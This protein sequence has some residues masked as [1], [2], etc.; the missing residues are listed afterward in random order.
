MQIACRDPDR[1]S[2]G[3][4]SRAR[5]FLLSSFVLNDSGSSST[6]PSRL[7]RMFVEYQPVDAEQPRLEARRDDRLDQ[8]LAGLQILARRAAIRSSAPAR[9][10]PARRRSGSAPRSRTAC[11]SLNRRVRVNHARRNRRIVGLE[12]L[13]RTP[14][15]TGAHGDSVMKI[16]VLPH[17]TSTSRSQLVVGLELADVGDQLLGQI[18]LVLALLDVRAVEPLHVLAIEHRRHRL[19]R[20]Q[21]VLDLIEER[22]PRARRPS[23]PPRSSCPRRCPS[24]RT[25]GRRGWPAAR[26]PES[27]GDRFSVRLPRR[28]VPIWVSEPMG[29]AM[30]F[31]IAMMPAMVV[32]LTAPRPTSRMPSLPSAGAIESP[33][34][35]GE[36]YIR[37]VPGF[38]VPGSPFGF[39][40]LLEWTNPEL[41]RGSRIEREPDR[42]TGSSNRIEQPDREPEPER[43]TPEPGTP[44]PL[45]QT[46][47]MPTTVYRDRLARDPRRHRRYEERN[48]AG[49]LVRSA[50][51]A[52]RMS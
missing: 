36:N 25:R 5:D 21:L 4:C 19:D 45:S 48:E 10:A 37:L 29:F 35:T 1:D 2:A 51:P 18:L 43:G 30:P 40:F 27:S 39:G 16:S 44:E 17:Q 33:L 23:W 22:R 50:R 47:E 49:D 42:A 24:R 12:A 11:P 41:E 38:R 15:A 28:I 20:R 9:A 13:S 32:V 52:E 6:S 31:R 26:N 14:P 8:R 46:R 3:R 34:V 7:P